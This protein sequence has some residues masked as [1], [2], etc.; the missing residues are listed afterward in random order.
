MILNVG[1]DAE[2]PDHLYLTGG[3]IKWYSYYERV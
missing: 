1:E 2:E 3:N